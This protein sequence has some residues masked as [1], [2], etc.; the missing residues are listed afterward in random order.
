LKQLQRPGFELYPSLKAKQNMHKLLRSQWVV[1]APLQKQTE[2]V[3]LKVASYQ[4]YL[5]KG[6][7]SLRISK[8]AL[9]AVAT[10]C[11][12]H[13]RN[14]VLSEIPQKLFLYN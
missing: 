1:V 8:Q 11:D 12:N 2:N 3:N 4:N 6:E 7:P 13:Q 14:V 9:A 10:W 5:T